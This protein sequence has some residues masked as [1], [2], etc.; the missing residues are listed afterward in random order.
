[1]GR[2][3]MNTEDKKQ[4]KLMTLAPRTIKLLLDVQEK[5][6]MSASEYVDKLVQSQA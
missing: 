3:K 5:T 1:M 4:R 2:P 6:G